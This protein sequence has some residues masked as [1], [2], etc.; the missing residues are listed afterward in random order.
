MPEMTD[1]QAAKMLKAMGQ[2]VNEETIKEAKEMMH[3]DTRNVKVLMTETLTQISS[4]ELTVEDF[5]LTLPEGAVLEESH[6][7]Y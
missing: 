1:E 7:S 4:P 3:G 5:K 6:A 2:E